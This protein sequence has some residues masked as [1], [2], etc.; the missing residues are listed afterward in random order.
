MEVTRRSFIKGSLALGALTAGG[1]ALSACAP[2]QADKANEMSDDASQGRWSWSIAPR[3]IDDSQVSETL[4]CDVC[5]VGAGVAGNPAALYATMQ[6]LKVVVLQ[7]GS[8]N[9]V[10]GQASGI[11]NDIHEDEL[12]IKTDVLVDLQKYAD[13]A[14]G[15]ANI[16]LVRNIMQATGPAYAWLT[17]I[18]TEPKPT[19]SKSGD[20]VRYQFILNDDIATRYEGWMQFHDN[21]VARAEQEAATY[22]YDT[23][24]VQ[25]IQ[26]NDGTINGVFG[27]AKDDSYV[28]VN[29]AKG[30][31]LC[32]G[33]I[34]DDEEMLEAFCPEMIGVPTRHGAPCNTGDGLKMGLWVG[35]SI[36]NP[37]SGVQMH[38]DPSGL[39]FYSPFSG[40]PWLHVNIKGERFTNEN[41]NFQNISTAIA[42]QPEHRAFQII[43]SHLM[44]HATDYKNGGRPGTQEALDTALEAGA[45][46]KADTLEELCEVANLPYDAVKKTV[47]RYNE[48]V[49]KGIDEDYAVDASV[50][51]WNGIKDA[52]F[53]AME[54]MPARLVAAQGL[55]C[56]EYLQVLNTDFEPIPKLYAAGNVQGSFFGYDYPVNGFGGFSNSRSVTGGILAVKSL[57]GTFDDPII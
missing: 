44:E 25:L 7:K 49:D 50:F 27:Q 43:D 14:D 45:I 22:R 47:D 21:I 46:L 30:V 23:P 40:I 10:N 31:I 51:S 48:L 53:Y 54:R 5:I 12:G 52:P 4:D 42:A 34:S 35:A 6:G 18:I 15:K 38:I 28:K 33:D 16:K 56:N 32:T 8:K 2:T 41:V 39:P 36:D 17:S 1:A 3:P 20:H 37:P 19:F 24:A 11:W 29:A 55:T 26:A 57:M 13:Y 9:Q